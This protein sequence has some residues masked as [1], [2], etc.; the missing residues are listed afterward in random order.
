MVSDYFYLLSKN[1][2]WLA[3]VQRSLPFEE[4]VHRPL[5]C[6]LYE[7]EDVIVLS[8]EPS[9]ESATLEILNKYLRDY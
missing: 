4:F 6:K 1:A 7:G 2:E 9:R 5:D 8:P 3:A